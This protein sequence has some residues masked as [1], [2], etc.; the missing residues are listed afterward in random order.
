MRDQIVR[1]AAGVVSAVGVLVL[2][3]S[4]MLLGAQEA[5]ENRRIV[6]PNTPG[7]RLPDAGESGLVQM[8]PPSGVRSDRSHG[9]LES[10]RARALADPSNYLVVFPE[11]EPPPI[12]DQ[13]GR[14][15]I[16]T[17]GCGRFIS[18]GISY[19][20]LVLQTNSG[21]RP[22]SPANARVVESPE[23][24][25]ARLERQMAEDLRL[26]RN[27]DVRA[28]ED[29]LK[30]QAQALR[31]GMSLR[32]I[33]ELL[34]EPSQAWCRRKIAANQGGYEPVQPQDLSGRE[35][36]CILI[37]SPDKNFKRWKAGASPYRTLEVLLDENSQVQSWSWL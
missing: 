28:R 26:G 2:S 19:R 25:A 30:Q 31:Q 33:M 27:Q 32:Q 4:L 18:N 36:R 16:A 6:L 5:K 3:N 14:F 20:V 7:P 8:Y 11:A 1:S 15:W 9:V 10:L 17:N 34:G 29:K 23:Q 35:G 13:P 37:F 12:L 24:G 22:S 21:A